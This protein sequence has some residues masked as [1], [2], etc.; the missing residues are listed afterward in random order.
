[1]THKSL[2]VNVG[3]YTPISEAIFRVQ[4]FKLFINR[5]IEKVRNLC[6]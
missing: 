1:M 2:I 5:I 3:A 6:L 4:E